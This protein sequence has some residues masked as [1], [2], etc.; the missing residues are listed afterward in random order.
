MQFNVI[1]YQNPETKQHEGIVTIDGVELMRGSEPS[2]D[3]AAAMQDTRNEFIG[4]L[5][6]VLGKQA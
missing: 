3:A 5:R 1:T 2:M 6:S 4:K